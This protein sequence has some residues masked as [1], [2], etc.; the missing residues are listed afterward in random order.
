MDGLGYLLV[1]TCDD[2]SIGHQPATSNSQY[3]K[4]RYPENGDTEFKLQ[5]HFFKN[6]LKCIKYG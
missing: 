5:L 3:T 2:V 6:H 1:A 4:F